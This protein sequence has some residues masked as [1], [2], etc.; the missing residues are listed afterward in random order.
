MNT[1]GAIAILLLAA[2]QAP[3]HRLDEYLQGTLV[4]VE[5]DR[6]RAEITLSPGVAVFPIVLADMDR[7]RDGVVSEAE[8]RAYAERVLR[9]LSLTMDGHPLRPRLV[10]MQFGT[11]EEMKEG[12][13]EIRIELSADLPA[14][15]S[16]RRI[17]LENRHQSRIA[18]Y[19][20]NCLVPPDPGI[21][22][23]AQS[24]NYTQS[25][26]EL[27]YVQVGVSAGLLPMG[28]GDG[29][30]GAIALVLFARFAL[31]WRERAGLSEAHR[32]SE[33][34]IIGFR[35]DGPQDHINFPRKR[36]HL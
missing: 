21:R 18:A 19:Q 25:E 12:R 2:A 8:Q 1:Y 3:A 32:S 30:V 16:E 33:L 20:V 23:V 15:G 22:I 10:S 27:R 31:L 4:S 24:R 28:S 6:L 17:R 36:L 11:I 14:G 34:N 26:Y 13:G 35:K 9:D 5:K 7:D 29:W